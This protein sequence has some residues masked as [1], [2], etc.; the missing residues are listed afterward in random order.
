MPDADDIADAIADAATTPKSATVDGNNVTA[1]SVDELAQAQALASQRAL[2]SV[3]QLF[4]HRTRLVA[5]PR[6]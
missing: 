6:Q 1:R 3:A 5:G 2:T 4:G